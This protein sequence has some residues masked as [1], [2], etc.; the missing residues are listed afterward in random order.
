M[1][2]EVFYPLG[3]FHIEGPRWLPSPALTCLCVL[4]QTDTNIAYKISQN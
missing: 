2:N 4:P 1:F 3:S